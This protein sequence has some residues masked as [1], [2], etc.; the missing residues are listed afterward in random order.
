MH[1]MKYEISNCCV[2]PPLHNVALGKPTFQSSDKPR[3]DGGSEKAVDGNKDSDL[4]NGNS[5]IWTDTE[6]QPHWEVDLQDSYDIYEVIITNRQDCCS[7]RLKDALIRVGDSENFEEN[8]VCGEQIVG[9]D[10]NAETIVM[11]CGCKTPMRGRYVSL[12]LID[13]TQM[14]HV[15][16]VEVMVP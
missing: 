12:Q 9:N 8:P 10:A 13:R 3:Q 6:Y 2:P 7:F 5:C 11:T 14:L 1:T 16:E 4:E 15:C